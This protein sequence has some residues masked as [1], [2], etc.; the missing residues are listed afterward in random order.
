MAENPFAHS[1]EWVPVPRR[2]GL[3]SRVMWFTFGFVACFVL[4]SI[5]FSYASYRNYQA[6]GPHDYSRVWPAYSP[7]TKPEWLEH[8]K[9][10]TLNGFAIVA[11]DDEKN[12][13][14]MVWPVD[15]RLMTSYEDSDRD[16]HADSISFWD[17][18]G[19]IFQFK[20]ADGFKQCDFTD[21]VTAYDGTTFF[22]YDLDGVFDFKVQTG[23]KRGLW[24]LVDSRWCPLIPEGDLKGRVEVNGEWKR[25]I[26]VH[27]QWRLEEALNPEP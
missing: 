2:F 17:K 24:L 18:K 1:N 19:R 5:L 20:V 9:F 25:A 12:A 13:S 22:D 21:D 14:A 10:R 26:N 4:C 8:S 7:E 15:G 11:A 3:G 6:L 27:D 16:G 23:P